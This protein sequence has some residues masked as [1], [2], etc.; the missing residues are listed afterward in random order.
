MSVI[1]NILDSSIN[2]FEAQLGSVATNI[3]KQLLPYLS[4]LQLEGSLILSND[5]N[6]DLVL[7][8]AD[9]F[10][11]VLQNAGYTDLM[12][13]YVDETS[14]IIAKIKKASDNTPLPYK[15]VATD[16]KTFEA[17]QRIDLMELGNIGQ[18]AATVLQTGLM[19]SVL[20]GQSYDTMFRDL[21][22]KLDNNLVRYAKTYITTA[23]S[24]L[25]QKMEDLS[26]E[27]RP[28][29]NY[30]E[31]IGPADAKNRD[32]C[33]EGLAKRVFDDVAKGDFE[34]TYGLRYNCRHTFHLITKE[35]YDKL[36]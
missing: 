18:K 28:G 14:S 30:W 11:T 17:L 27:N 22:D 24:Q 33:I 7:A 19:N 6:L 10:Q 35:R 12:Q 29:E 9:E 5:V 21:V 8:F 1:D 3:Q 13:K 15:F 20:A 34:N 36:K 31:Y 32:E 25:L 26:A 4:Q 16:L 23:R 2:T